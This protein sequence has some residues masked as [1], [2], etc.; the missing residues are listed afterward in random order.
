MSVC[1]GMEMRWLANRVVCDDRAEHASCLFRREP[2]ENGGPC[3]FALGEGKTPKTG[4][5][6][7]L[8]ACRHVFQ[9]PFLVA[10]EWR[11]RRGIAPLSPENGEVGGYSGERGFP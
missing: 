2:S 10:G 7:T 1:V 6:Q 3:T 4:A 11:R 8:P 5:R 9:V